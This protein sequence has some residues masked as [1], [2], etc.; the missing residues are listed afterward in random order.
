MFR[1][2]TW[3]LVLLIGGSPL[4]AQAASPGLDRYGGCTAW[5]DVFDPKFPQAVRHMADNEKL[6]P[7]QKKWVLFAFV[8]QTD[9]MRGISRGHPHLGWACAATNGCRNDPAASSQG[10][11]RRVLVGRTLLPVAVSTGKSARP[12]TL[13]SRTVLRGSSS[14]PPA[15]PGTWSARPPTSGLCTR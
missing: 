5:A 7:E 11:D 13:V 9:Y 15:I 12:T 6:S 10:H 1:P 4:P 14:V 8:E 3:I 2:L